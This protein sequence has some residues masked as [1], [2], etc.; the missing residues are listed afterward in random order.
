MY[1][2]Q[3]TDRRSGFTLV[4]VLVVIAIL[5]LLAAL[6]TTNVFKQYGHARQE[7]A[8]ME[9]AQIHDVTRIFY[10]REN[11]VPTMQDLID[12]PP[13]LD[14]YTEI[15]KDPWLT[16]YELRPGNERGTWEVLSFGPDRL[17]GTDDDIS[18][19]TVK[20]RGR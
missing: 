1:M 11:R 6:V 13:E 15:P 14:G 19:R 4:E 18:S 7:T 10:L 16:P 17:E 2:T 20:Q 9:I 3:P 5:G 12:P 8:R